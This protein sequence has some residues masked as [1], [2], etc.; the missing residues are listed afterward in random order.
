VMQVLIDSHQHYW[1]LARGDYGWLTEESGV[2]YRDYL[3]KDLL[4]ILERHGIRQ[5]IVVQAAPT[6]DETIFLLAL[7]KENLSIAGVVGWVDMESLDSQA[8][9]SKLAQ[10]PKF[11][12]IRPMLQDINDPEWVLGG[13]LAP[14]FNA[15]IENGLSFDALIL[16]HHLY[17]IEILAE[18]Y[19]KLRIVIDHA[20]KPNIA[21][22][23]IDD[24]SRAI[25]SIATH[26]NVYCK[27]SGLVTEAGERA[28]KGA[29]QPYVD[30]L[31]ESFGAKRLMWG[32]DWP[33]VKT[34]MEYEQWL[35]M[36][37]ELISE[38]TDME[39][40]Q[41]RGVTAHEFYCLS[42]S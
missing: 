26:Q 4:P 25:K 34:S 10:D 14:T 19:P 30:C 32:S 40:R 15:L 33:V 21:S 3:P 39:Q 36:A 2:L 12:G 24:W 8:L 37:N 11:L 13:L 20:A 9:L 23:E 35:V 42:G 29:L 31:I 38:L 18:R 1:Q 5:S 17:I 28:T 7:A 41:I 22:S 27:L 16:P 6:L